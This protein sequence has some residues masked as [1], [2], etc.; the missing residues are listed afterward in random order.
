MKVNSTI[1]GE[2]TA[3]TG[4][5]N[6]MKFADSFYDLALAS[7]IVPDVYPDESIYQNFCLNDGLSVSRWLRI[8]NDYPNIR[9]Q[10][11]FYHPQIT[12]YFPSY[13]LEG[14]APYQNF[15]LAT[16]YTFEA[17]GKRIGMN[18]TI[19][20]IP[21]VRPCTEMATE[22]LVLCVYCTLVTYETKDTT[23]SMPRFYNITREVDMEYDD[24]LEMIHNDDTFWDNHYISRMWV[25]VCYGTKTNRDF[26]SYYLGVG[27]SRY[28]K[29]PATTLFSWGD[30]DIY[31][32]DYNKQ[33]LLMPASDLGS[34]SNAYTLQ[35]GGTWY[36]RFNSEK[37]R[38]LYIAR[39][40]SLWSIA[41]IQNSGYDSRDVHLTTYIDNELYFRSAYALY[42]C[43]G[44]KFCGNIDD[45]RYSDSDDADIFSRGKPTED[46]GIDPNN[47]ADEDDINDG[48]VS[49]PSDYGDNGFN[50]N[51][52]VI[53][54]NNYVDE[55]PL[56]EPA[57]S[58]V[59]A[60]NRSYAISY[61]SVK[62]LADWLWNADEDIFD[63]IVK[64]LA[65]HG[66]NPIDGIISVR[67][68]PFP[69]NSL[70]TVGSSE[71]IKVGRNASPI[72]G[73]P[74]TY[75]SKAIVDLGKCYF[76]PH[77]KNFLDY[78]PYT[79]ARLYIPYIGIIPVDTIEFMGHEISVKM[80][81]DIVTGAC[82]AMV[83]RDGIICTYAS[84]T[85]GVD[86][87]FSGTD[88]ANFASRMLSAT[89]GNLTDGFINAA[90]GAAS[91]SPAT[92]AYG[93][94][95]GVESVG[96][97]MLA[98]YTI[99]TDYVAGGSSTPNCGN[100]QPQYCYFIID[101]PIDIAPPNYGHFAGFACAET[102][103]LKTFH[104]FTICSN[105]DTS[106]FAQATE[107]ERDELKQLL[108]SGVFI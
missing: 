42:R 74:I 10:E 49:D 11:E 26:D 9:M 39:A 100:W 54:M 29:I 38:I 103:Q 72:E 40:N 59:G 71:I 34:Y 4:F 107:G 30:T 94:A 90:S 91:P 88:S 78:K 7:K 19:G 37:D 96:K 33:D 61:I 73:F 25:R 44:F 56:P 104:G 18:A 70:V 79:E 80:I 6:S 52:S 60:F 53:D 55:T 81:V 92:Q 102:G 58:V 99:G 15:G 46:G 47:T 51:E 13:G 101:R 5:P 50:G 86:I 85:I 66:E 69:V 93:L 63:E 97:A 16:N 68:Y 105:V 32:G 20:S 108:E 75:N 22:Y 14:G 45:A 83:Y 76:Y 28:P 3:I 84:G 12:N 8:K 87:P 21:R 17:Y 67:L 64:G 2:G 27:T 57:L 48:L 89:I 82:C 106:G 24:V 31:E 98:N 41:C 65:L 77:F 62:N 1:Y 95:R 35:Q 23:F 43:T 36:D